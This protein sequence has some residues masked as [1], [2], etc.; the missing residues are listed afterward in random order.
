MARRAIDGVVG[1]ED[2]PPD[3]TPAD[4]DLDGLEAVL[5]EEGED[6]GR[7]GVGPVGAWRPAERDLPRGADRRPIRMGPRDRRRIHRLIVGVPG[8]GDRAGLLRVRV[9]HRD[10]ARSR[11][12]VQE[13]PIGDCGHE[14]GPA[15]HG[16]AVGGV[17]EAVLDAVLGREHPVVVRLREVLDL[18]KRFVLRVIE[19]LRAVDQHEIVDTA[20]E[21]ELERVVARGRGVLDV[22]QDEAADVEE[23]AEPGRLRLVTLAELV[24]RAAAVAQGDLRCDT[25]GAGRDHDGD[26]GGRGAG[27]QIVLERVDAEGPRR[28]AGGLRRCGHRAR[29]IINR[30]L[31][32]SGPRR[33]LRRDLRDRRRVIRRRRDGHDQVVARGA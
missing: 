20:P 28:W 5:L 4:P 21:H 26:L 32:S 12:P 3:Q 30:R 2:V 31:G 11:H 9:L 27:E 7:A 8:R 16:L 13:I 25:R 33:R 1:G 17:A 29:A 10:T 15:G 18:E 24:D 23:P 19:A 6:G 14:V 22:A